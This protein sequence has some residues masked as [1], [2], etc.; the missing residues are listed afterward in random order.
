MVTFFLTV[1][2]NCKPAC[3]FKMYPTF[4]RPDLKPIVCKDTSD[5]SAWFALE[6]SSSYSLGSETSA[7]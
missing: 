4:L 3:V 7:K 6:S 2:N 5:F 1:V